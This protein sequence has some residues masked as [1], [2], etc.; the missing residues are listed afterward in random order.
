MQHGNGGVSSGGRTPLDVLMATMTAQE[1]AGITGWLGGGPG[2]G[3]PAGVCPQALTEHH[4]KVGSDRFRPRGD[5]PQ[6]VRSVGVIGGGTAGYLTALGLKAKRP[7]LDVTLVESRDIPIIGVGEATVSY[8][9]TFL[10]HFLDIDPAELYRKVRPTWKF[11]IKFNWGP[12]PDGFMA[13]FDWNHHSIGALGALEAEN[14]VNG[15]T[16]QS[17]MMMA[18]RT[19]IYE[20]DGSYVSLMKYLPFAYHLDNARFVGFLAELAA[21]RGVHHVDARLAEVVLGADEWVDHLR[22][23][24]G[25]QL[26]YDF[27]VDCTGFRSMLLGAALD[28]RFVS[29]QD[30]LFT[31]SAV[32]ANRGH[33]G[34][35]K[36]YTTATTMDAGWCWTIPTPDSDHL[37]YVYSSS[38]LSDDDAAHELTERFPGADGLRQVRFRSGRHEKAWRGNVMAI[39]NS[40]AFVEPLEST[41]LLMAA[42]SVQALTDVLPASWSDTHLREV[43]NAGLGRRWDAVRWFL[44]VH[45]K[46][47]TRCDTPFW[48]EVR[49]RCDISGF[50][51]LLDL[52]QNGAPLTRRD[53]YLAGL[54][55]DAAPTYFG[56]GGIDNIL[57]GQKVP[58]RLLE[59]AEPIE[60]WRARRDAGAA[61][62]TRA[63]AQRE[64]LAAFHSAPELNNQLFDDADS[65]TGRPVA[66]YL[67]L[68]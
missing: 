17:L 33:G 5:D 21:E 37:G 61:L 27:Y 2:A 67:G 34:H 4:E 39:G 14:T 63:L 44:A 13:T 24:D 23:A 57:L 18:D 38:A 65:W 25:R 8:L 42:L 29:Y 68:L 28:T 10:H 16:A 60:Q 56:L 54:A 31:D 48:K 20:V 9:V 51:P 11:G 43:V 52:F 49:E 15:F 22:T 64:G 41:G 30:S 47:N 50:Q 62:V 45:Y 53:P 19:P 3:Q 35:L 6:A 46:F 59:R 66:G 26:R 36:P 12:D 1:R 58:A 7:W 32:T 55:L 40:Y